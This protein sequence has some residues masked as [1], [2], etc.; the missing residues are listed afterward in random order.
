[1][2]QQAGH[3]V[4]ASLP[5][6]LTANCLPAPVPPCR[7]LLAAL[8]E[9]EHR[10]DTVSLVGSGRTSWLLLFLGA[11]FL[12]HLCLR[13]Q[14]RRWWRQGVLALPT[15]AWAVLRCSTRALIG[16]PSHLCPFRDCYSESL[17]RRVRAHITD[18]NS[19]LNIPRI[20]QASERQRALKL[21]VAQQPVLVFLS[22]E[23]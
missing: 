2:V 12:L 11:G 20:P 8:H 7:A 16:L 19:V 21:L 15:E 6:Q 13:H 5:A 22:G 1:M 4:S 14:L 17:G 9:W 3:G 18:R 23:W 10:T